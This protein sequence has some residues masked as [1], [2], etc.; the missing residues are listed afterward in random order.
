MRDDHGGRQGAMKVALLTVSDS[1]AAGESSDLSGP[2]LHKKVAEAG[3]TVLGMDIAP[4]AAQRYESLRDE[5]GL[6][7]AEASVSNADF[8]S[9]EP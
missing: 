3:W 8:F 2:L 6:S 4:T 5:L 9:F 1:A 7:E